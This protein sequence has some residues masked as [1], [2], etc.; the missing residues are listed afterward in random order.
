MHKKISFV[1]RAERFLRFAFHPTQP[2]RSAIGYH[3]FTWPRGL[4]WVKNWEIIWEI[5][6]N[7]IVII[8]NSQ[9]EE[10]LSDGTNTNEFTCFWFHVQKKTCFKIRMWAGVLSPASVKLW[11]ILCSLLL[12]MFMLDHVQVLGIIFHL[13]LQVGCNHRILQESRQY[14]DKPLR[15][16]KRIVVCHQTS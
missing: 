6:R 12:A 2:A 14:W 1:F 4:G 3:R 5:M 16:S 8:S 7:M 11:V 9:S 10:K 15:V 13:V